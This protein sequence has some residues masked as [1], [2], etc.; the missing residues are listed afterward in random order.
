LELQLSDLQL[1]ELWLVV[2]LSI[3]CA[4]V[5]KILTLTLWVKYGLKMLVKKE[6]TEGLKWHENIK[7]TTH[8]IVLN[9]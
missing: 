2:V 3:Y 6:Q 9:S 1:F 7:N 4:M 5:K 8:C